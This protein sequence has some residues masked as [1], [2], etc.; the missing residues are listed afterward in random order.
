MMVSLCKCPP[1]QF[2]LPG[3]RFPLICMSQTVLIAPLDCSTCR[4]YTISAVYNK[5]SDEPVLY[6]HLYF[7]CIYAKS[8]FSHDIAHIAMK[9]IFNIQA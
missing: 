1:F 5:S 2:G 8:R 7:V 3:Q 6:L 4:S 9:M